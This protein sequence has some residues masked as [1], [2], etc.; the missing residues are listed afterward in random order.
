MYYNQN[1]H[2]KWHH[3]WTFLW[4]HPILAQLL[5]SLQAQRLDLLLVLLFLG[6]FQGDLREAV[7]LGEGVGPFAVH[8]MQLRHRLPV[9]AQQNNKTSTSRT[10]H[11]AYC[12]G[13]VAMTW[14]AKVLR[15]ILMIFLDFSHW[16]SR[17]Q[18][19]NHRPQGLQWGDF[20][21]WLHPDHSCKVGQIGHPSG[22]GL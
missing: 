7:E 22:P 8:H 16:C 15:Q 4:K 18:G 12:G 2:G 1:S 10:W 14:L 6:R 9:P 3:P 19:E 5:A 13:D 11:G 21:L 17:F 20:P